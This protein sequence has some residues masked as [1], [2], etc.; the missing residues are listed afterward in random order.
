MSCGW[1]GNRR[2]G[3]AQAMRQTSVVIHLLAHGLRKGY[4]HPATLLMAHSILPNSQ[5]VTL[6]P[7]TDDCVV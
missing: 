1:E 6:T 2:S 7:V 3:I 4:G 5:V